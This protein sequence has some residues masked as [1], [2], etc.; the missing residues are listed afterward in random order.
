MHAQTQVEMTPEDVATGNPTC[1]RTCPVARAM[2]RAMTADARVD[3]SGWEPK[4]RRTLWI[5]LKV[6]GSVA[7]WAATHTASPR[8]MRADMPAHVG[9]WINA[10]DDAGGHGQK[11]DM[12]PPKPFLLTW[13]PRVPDWAQAQGGLRYY[14]TTKLWEDD[15]ADLWPLCAAHEDEARVMNLWPVS[16]GLRA[17][18]K[19]LNV[20]DERRATEC[21][22]C[23]DLKGAG[24]LGEDGCSDR[25]HRQ[26]TELCARETERALFLCS[27]HM[28]QEESDPP[29][30]HKGEEMLLLP[31][32]YIECARCLDEEVLHRL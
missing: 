6:K 22:R 1:P 18:V 9:D 23:R 4:P 3:L 27:E 2:L 20:P 11:P 8:A 32:T 13:Y 29:T 14:G 25:L 19:L 5:E 31:S 10:Y 16:G 30:N 24:I 7:M 26:I 17:D 12:T 15:N 21:R 28:R